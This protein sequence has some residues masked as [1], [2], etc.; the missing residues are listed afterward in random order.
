MKTCPICKARCF[1]DMEICYGCMHRFA[2]DAP[3]REMRIEDET[4][5]R[6]LPLRPGAMADPGVGAESGYRGVHAAAPTAAKRQSAR[7]DPS[8][9]FGAMGGED[10]YRESVGFADESLLGKAGGVS[11]TFPPESISSLTL[12][13][14]PFASISLGNGYRLVVSVE[15]E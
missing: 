5:F 9:V 1:D 3:Q 15:T 6:E 10:A 4:E 2:G 14:G 7:R 12:A 11:T 8:R 13:I